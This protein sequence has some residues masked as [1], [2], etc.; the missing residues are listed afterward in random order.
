M[1]Y[2]TYLQWHLRPDLLREE[3]NETSGMYVHSLVPC[4]GAAKPSFDFPKNNMFTY[5]MFLMIDFENLM[6][7]KFAPNYMIY[8]VELPI[9]KL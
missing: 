7:T 6:G 5:T 3:S 1:H 9:L 8:S 2:P 4:G